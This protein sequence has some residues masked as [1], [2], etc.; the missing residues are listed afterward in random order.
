MYN[1][2]NFE[3]E[4]EIKKLLYSETKKR[5]SA[6]YL[7]DGKDDSQCFGSR[8][9]NK[10]INAENLTDLLESNNYITSKKK[11]KKINP[12]KRKQSQSKSLSSGEDIILLKTTPKNQDLLNSP[13]QEYLRQEIQKNQLGSKQTIKREKEKKLN[14]KNIKMNKKHFPFSFDLES[15][16]QSH[17]TLSSYGII[18][19][20]S[21]VLDKRDKAKTERN[22]L[23]RKKSE[24]NKRKYDFKVK[25]KTNKVH[26]SFV[27]VSSILQLNDLK[28]RCKRYYKSFR[29]NTI[30]KKKE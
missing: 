20:K 2:K 26:L 28:L 7:K 24:T 15:R 12:K 30:K 11:V 18:K 3:S 27:N 23:S 17:N 14:K 9:T 8:N 19:N 1:K 10:L 5:S 6:M 13:I 29:H 22:L 25:D 21:S 16:T 4:Q